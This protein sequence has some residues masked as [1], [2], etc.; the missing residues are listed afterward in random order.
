VTRSITG[1]AVLENPERVLKPG[2]LMSLVLLKNPRD[3]VVVP[4]EALIPSG[5]QHHV[6][7]V[8][9]SAAQPLA[10]RRPVTIGARRPGEVEIRGGLE[11]GEFV[12]THGTLSARPGQPVSVTAVAAGGESL[13]ELLTRAQGRSE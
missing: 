12:V 9:P 3:A 8:D 7:V 13:Q 1:R 4:E 6:L 2:L 11:A 10:Q 5:Q